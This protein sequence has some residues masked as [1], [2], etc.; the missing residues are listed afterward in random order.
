MQSLSQ[1]QFLTRTPTPNQ[2]PRRTAMPTQQTQKDR[3]RSQTLTLKQTLRQNAMTAATAMPTQPRQSLSLSQTLNP[4]HFR[5]T[6]GPLALKP[7]CED[8]TSRGLRR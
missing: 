4:T 6:T 1:S 5:N 7:R 8:E 3:I 2:T